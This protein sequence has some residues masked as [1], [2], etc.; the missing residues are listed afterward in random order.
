MKPL[1]VL[2]VEDDTEVLEV[3]NEY[4]QSLGHQVE[5]FPN[6]LLALKALEVDPQRFDVALVDHHM[7]GMT[8]YEFVIRIRSLGIDFPVVLSS[9]N[10][11]LDIHLDNIKNVKFIDKPYNLGA[12]NTLLT[13]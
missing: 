2:L 5:F 8:G 1:H 13:A 7:P 4:L 3:L 10:H 12:L 9:G 11:A 6:P